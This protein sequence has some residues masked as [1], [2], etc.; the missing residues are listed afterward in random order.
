MCFYG[1]GYNGLHLVPCFHVLLMVLASMACWHSRCLLLDCS[2]KLL[3]HNVL[4][5]CKFTRTLVTCICHHFP[6][7][8][9][10]ATVIPVQV[11]GI[12][13]EFLCYY[14]RLNNNNIIIIIIIIILLLSLWLLLL[15][16]TASCHMQ[17][18]YTPS[19]FIAELPLTTI[20][21]TYLEASRHSG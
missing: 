2:N 13:T 19:V 21:M 16:E 5:F 9:I 4:L 17:F 12:L 20:N 10:N 14:H 3:S 8:L 18:N 1:I 11:H 6:N 7:F 15:D